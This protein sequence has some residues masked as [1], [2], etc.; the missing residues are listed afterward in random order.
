MVIHSPRSGGSTFSS[1]SSMT[2]VMGALLF[3]VQLVVVTGQQC[4]SN[5]EFESFFEQSLG[6]TSLPRNGSCCQAD[7]CD[8]PCPEGVAEPKRGP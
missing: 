6:V 8:L 1:G 4:L 3:C 2:L 5:P 7:V